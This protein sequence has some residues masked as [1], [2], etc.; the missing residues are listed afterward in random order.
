[1]KKLI[2]GVAVAMMT[3]LAY[4]EWTNQDGYQWSYATL[5]DGGIRITDVSPYPEGEFEIPASLDGLTVVEFDLDNYSAM[6][7][8]STLTIPNS[9]S[10]ITCSCDH[11]STVRISDLKSF[12]R[13]CDA[14]FGSAV[15]GYRLFLNG[16]EVKSL[17]IHE[18]V[19]RDGY[20]GVI[21]CGF[22]RRMLGSFAGCLSLESI[23]ISSEVKTIGGFVA[24]SNLVTVTGGANLQNVGERFLRDTAWWEIQPSGFVRLSNWILGYK[25]EIEA[26]VVIP[27]G[28]VGFNAGMLDG[29]S[30]V[31]IPS[32]VKYMSGSAYVED[33]E[34]LRINVPSMSYWANVES[35]GAFSDCFYRIFANGSEATTWNPTTAPKGIPDSCL[36]IKSLTLPNGVTNIGNYAFFNCRNLASVKLPASMKS[37]G[38]G[39]FSSE[40]I[41][42]YDEEN[43]DYTYRYESALKTVTL[44]EGLE[45]I[46]DEAF[47]HCVSLDSIAIPST[48]EEFGD[49]VFA[50][51]TS[52]KSVTF[53]EG[54]KS[55]GQYMF[56]NCRAIESVKL[57]SSMREIGD[58]AFFCEEIEV[59]NR[60]TDDY[61]RFYESALKSVELNDGLECIGEDAFAHCVS[62][63]S[64]TIPS[65]V[66]HFDGAFSGCTALK[67][68]N[69][70]NGVRRIDGSAFEDCLSLET[71]TLPDS[72]VGIGGSAFRGCAAL[73]QVVLSDK[74]ETIGQDAF[75]GCVSMN[76]VSLPSTVSS[77]G[78]G[79][80]MECDALVDFSIASGNKRYQ[81][82]GGLIIDYVSHTVIGPY[83]S[84]TEVVI[85]YGV[86]NVGESAFYIRVDEVYSEPSGQICCGMSFERKLIG[87]VTHSRLKKVEI[88]ESVT[89]IAF[90]SLAGTALESITIPGSVQTLASCAIGDCP[91]LK[92][93]VLEEGVVQ[94]GDHAFGRDMGLEQI[95]VPSS[96]VSI[97]NR[98]FNTCVK[99]RN[100]WFMGD[101]PN[102]DYH[103]GVFDDAADDL[104]T[105][106]QSLANGW[107]AELWQGEWQERAIVEEDGIDALYA[108]NANELE[109]V[110]DE[111]IGEFVEDAPDG[112]HA[113]RSADVGEGESSAMGFAVSGAGIL[114]FAW[115]TE[116]DARYDELQLVVDGEIARRTAGTNDW[117]TAEIEFGRSDYEIEWRFCRGD[118]GPDGG[119]GWLDC[120]QWSP[121][122]IVTL[123]CNGGEC[124]TDAVVREANRALGA[125]PE[126]TWEGHEFLGWFTAADG[127]API[128]EGMVVATDLICHAHWQEIPTYGPWGEAEAV[129]NPDKLGPTMLTDMTLELNGAA[130]AVGD[131]VAAFRGD[132]GALCGLG[133]VMDDSGTLTMACYAPT[134]VKLHFKVWVA[135]SGGRSWWTATR[136][137]TS[138]RRRAERSSRDM[139][140]W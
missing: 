77:I 135:A 134:G 26:D 23:S 59:Y 116:C 133:K 70:A 22:S 69:I 80:F 8:V 56:W 25:G 82:A 76:G 136:R 45:Y 109:W 86:R 91:N 42:E 117:A 12:Y 43:D 90:Q 93:V 57:P 125:L 119:C 39:A 94:I 48:I 17:D 40:E 115:R 18:N 88:P 46:G 52:L 108:V 130:G 13:V 112:I 96:V 72:V 75:R 6:W 47:A 114:R 74:L 101:K 83:G 113:A 38:W 15:G 41:E 67:S 99:L 16:S 2:L 79:A 103:S 44:N 85:P 10:N 78:I 92:K 68:A 21:C 121:G 105:H 107:D 62:L 31:T 49:D 106:V 55:I 24:C 5:R 97:G 11:V 54:L 100:V 104:I 131:V 84:P 71:V 9:V 32:S 111:W 28:T 27:S 140:S 64:I 58:S 127:G 123:D 122:Y 63:G 65:T 29:V 14:Y 137:A 7:N 87:L 89:N 53:A 36:S 124:A 20:S 30:S 110:A 118:G 98:A 102:T 132:T 60:E 50:S 138:R 1:M 66:T 120:V 126:P 61:D 35:R 37:I 19:F 3:V 128:E 34:V 73:K 139:R 33:G 51:C 81:A 4:A 95:A 129:K